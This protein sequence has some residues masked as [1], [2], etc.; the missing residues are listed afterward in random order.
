M[1]RQRKDKDEPFW[2]DPVDEEDRLGGY[3]RSGMPSW[4]ARGRFPHADEE[5]EE[6]YEEEGLVVNQPGVDCVAM[7][8]SQKKGASSSSGGGAVADAAADQEKEKLFKEKEKANERGGVGATSPLDMVPDDHDRESDNNPDKSDKAE[9]DKVKWELP[10]EAKGGGGGGEATGGGGGGKAKGGGGCNRK[11]GGGGKAKGGGG[12]M[13]GLV[14]RWV[15]AVGK[16]MP[17]A[18]GGYGGKG[19]GGEDNEKGGGGGKGGSRKGI[20]TSVAT[21]VERCSEMINQLRSDE[22]VLLS[23][24]GEVK[25]ELMVWILRRAAFE[26]QDPEMGLDS[27]WICR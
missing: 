22:A 12:V 5:E 15:A 4:H 2:E 13:A 25:S 27:S 20:Y 3:F 10:S 17:Q 6:E 7:A 16:Q 14:R 19:G 9:S 21:D 1:K 18:R 24:L 8:R 26:D 23:R 11:G